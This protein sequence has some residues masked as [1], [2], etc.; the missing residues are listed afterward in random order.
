MFI[1]CTLYSDSVITFSCNWNFGLIRWLVHNKLT[2]CL[3][4]M[5]RRLFTVKEASDLIPWLEE[6]LKELALLYSRLRQAQSDYQDLSRRRNNNGH[7]SSD[8]EIESARKDV[9]QFSGEIESGM[10]VILREGILIRHIES[11][12]VDFPSLREGREVYLCWLLG[13]NEVGFWHETNV[14]YSSRQPW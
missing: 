13:E 6:K 5:N 14:G 12:L 9:T 2:E 4:Y 1:Y 7:S 3:Y 11:G 10:E 8:E